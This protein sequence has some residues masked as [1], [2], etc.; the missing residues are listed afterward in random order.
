PQGS[1]SRPPLA[2][3]AAPTGALP[4]TPGLPADR[5]AADIALRLPWAGREN[6]AEIL[7]EE[8]E[9]LDAVEIRIKYAGYIEREKRLAEKI[10]RLENLEIPADFDFRKITA[11]SM[12]SR[13]KLERYRP[14]TIAQA[15]RIP[16]VSPADISVLLVYFGR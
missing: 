1:P 16:G 9:V 5:S 15:S 7:R 6:P 12:E 14:R 3:D 8:R 2:A 10:L 13:I 11:L 4:Q